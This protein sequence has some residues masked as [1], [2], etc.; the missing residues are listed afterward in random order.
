MKIQIDL[1]SAAIGLII[2]SVTIF[3]IADS[4]NQNPVGRFQ[5]SSSYNSITILDTA[6]GEAWEHAATTEGEGGKDGKFWEPK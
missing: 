6:T 2:G 3:T 1:K 5:V 4:T